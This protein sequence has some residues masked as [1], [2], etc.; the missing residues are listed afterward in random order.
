MG[1]DYG[2]II[3]V[4]LASSV[5]IVALTAAMEPFQDECKW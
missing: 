4:K 3:F 2:Q 1:T 5:A